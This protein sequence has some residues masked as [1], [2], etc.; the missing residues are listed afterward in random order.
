MLSTSAIGQS[1][2]AEDS[3]KVTGKVHKCSVAPMMDVT[4]NAPATVMT[5]AGK[6]AFLFVTPMC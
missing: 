2:Q 3:W 1:G 6:M 5:M 4:N